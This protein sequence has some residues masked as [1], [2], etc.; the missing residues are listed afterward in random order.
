MYYLQPVLDSLE[1][2]F[3]PRRWGELQ[4]APFEHNLA[5][6][7]SSA[8]AICLKFAAFI[9]GF[10]SAATS[11]RSLIFQVLGYASLSSAMFT[12]MQ[13]EYKML[14]EKR[15]KV[16]RAADKYREE[17]HQRKDELKGASELLENCQKSLLAAEKEKE[18]AGRDMD[19][20][21]ANIKEAKALI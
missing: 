2:A 5:H 18:Y 16:M 3:P 20:V 15:D 7:E 9:I 6:L 12:G 19:R 21:R 17:M 11:D 14:K 4:G 8:A 10:N 13:Q 1:A